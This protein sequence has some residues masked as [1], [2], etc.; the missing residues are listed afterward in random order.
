[1]VELSLRVSD[2][3]SC[4]MLL[5]STCWLTFPKIFLNSSELQEAQMKAFSPP[6][7]LNIEYYLK[8]TK[9]WINCLKKHFILECKNDSFHIYQWQS[10][11]A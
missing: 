7:S 10:A 9:F 8:E 3:H 1:M 4:F 2:I 6:K 11:Y 5:R